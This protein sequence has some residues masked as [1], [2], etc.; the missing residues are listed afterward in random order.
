MTPYRD[1]LQADDGTYAVAKIEY[2]NLE[3]EAQALQL[4]CRLAEWEASDLETYEHSL[5]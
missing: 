5:E 1:V 3:T 4:A 2:E